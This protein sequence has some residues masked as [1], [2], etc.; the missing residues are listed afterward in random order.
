[1]PE[2]GK[3][4][5]IIGM[6]AA[7]A[8][9]VLALI[10]VLIGG[11][12]GKKPRTTD[13]ATQSTTLAA[14]SVTTPPATAP[15]AAPSAGA[16]LSTVLSWIRAGTPADASNFHTATDTGGTQSD[17]DVG[18][19]FVSPT[20]KIQCMTPKKSATSYMHG[21]SCLVN[22]DNPQPRPASLPHGEWVAS[23][24]DY[25]G[26]NA[27]IGT[28]ASD[29]GQFS[30]GSGSTLTYGSKLTF[31]D[32]ECRMDQTGLLCADQSAGTALQ[33]SSAGPVPF[34]CFTKTDGTSYAI[35]YG[36]GDSDESATATPSAPR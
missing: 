36:C 2:S 10:G 32:Y 30:L 18:L 33:L 11:Q 27:G 6:T 4:N 14:P 12:L 7:M 29:P 35:T 25:P 19:A 31:D 13:A 17:L 21:L 24:V 1:M 22:F 3:R 8:M 28:V 9:V 20:K 26:P 23:W 15:V 16:S 5:L 34:G